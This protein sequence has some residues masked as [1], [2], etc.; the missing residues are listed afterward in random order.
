MDQF[1]ES[2]SIVFRE[3]FPGDFSAWVGM[4]PA[5]LAVK[6]EIDGRVW[7]DDTGGVC[8]PVVAGSQGR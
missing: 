4:P 1:P 2:R 7:V 6:V 8:G 5:I 3:A